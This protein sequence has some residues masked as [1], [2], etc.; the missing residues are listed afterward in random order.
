[1]ATYP[2]L[3]PEAARSATAQAQERGRAGE[4][5]HACEIGVKRS[6]Y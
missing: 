5:H 2:G 1:M 6:V 3:Q 4:S